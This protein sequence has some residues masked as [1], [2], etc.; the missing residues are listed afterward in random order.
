MLLDAEQARLPTIDS[1]ALRAFSFASAS[2]KLA[3]V[4][5]GMVAVHALRMRNRSVVFSLHMTAGAG[6][7]P[8]LSEQR[9]EGS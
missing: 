7:G 6:N 2:L 5:V 3:P 4:R 1:V 9:K 8:M